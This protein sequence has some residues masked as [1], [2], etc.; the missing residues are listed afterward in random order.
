MQLKNVK[1]GIIRMNIEEYVQGLGPDWYWL[2]NLYAWFRQKIGFWSIFLTVADR[3]DA[4]VLEGY[5][6]NWKSGEKDQDSNYVLF[7]FEELRGIFVDNNW[8]EYMLVNAVH[9]NK[10]EINRM[11]GL[12]RERWLFKPA[13][14][15][16]KWLK[17]SNNNLVRLACKEL[18]LRNAKRIWV[19]NKQTRRALERMGFSD[20]QVHRIP[21]PKW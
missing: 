11:M 10:Q 16:E 19:R 2:K 5:H 21:V 3:Y 4:Y 18:D 8:R 15:K 14:S 12:V 7:S 13:W 1:Y 17:F 20:V 9:Y 6:L